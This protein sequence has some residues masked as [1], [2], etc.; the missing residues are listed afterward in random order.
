MRK[1]IYFA[2][3]SGPEWPEAKRLEH[4]FLTAKGRREFFEDGNDS[5]GLDVEDVD[6]TGALQGNAGRTDLHLTIQGHPDY[7]V[8]LQY[9]KVGGT[10][11]TYYSKGELKRLSEWVTTLHGDRM[12]I[13]L[14]VPFE[15][16]WLAIK[17][18]MEREGALP[19]SIEWVAGH[20]LP[21]ET[22]PDP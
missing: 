14:Y 13:G 9:R 3:F 19:T 10:N 17:E 4:Y 16:A 11:E 6:D 18:F 15:I 8:L 5:W 1:S 20:D 21:P 22:F 7:G 2:A 12:P